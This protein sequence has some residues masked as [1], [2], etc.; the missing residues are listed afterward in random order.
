MKSYYDGI[1]EF[2]QKCEEIVQS[3]DI[4]DEGAIFIQTILDRAQNELERE[5][6][7]ECG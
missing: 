3:L 7:E 5:N 6:P 4:S 1:I 2:E